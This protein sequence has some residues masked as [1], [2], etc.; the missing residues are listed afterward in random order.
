MY[1]LLSCDHN[2]DS[3]TSITFWNPQ[4]GSKLLS[5]RGPSAS[6]A[7]LSFIRN[8]G[9][10]IAE[11]GKPFIHFWQTGHSLQTS[12]RILCP[13]KVNAMAWSHTGAFLAVAIKE[14]I[15]IWQPSSGRIVCTLDAGHHRDV[16]VLKFAKDLSYLVSGGADGLVLAW[17]FTPAFTMSS[18][19]PMYSWANHSFGVTDLW[20]GIGG[21]KARIYS[22]SLD[23]TMKIYSLMTG[24]V[25]LSIT[26]PF[27]LTSVAADLVEYC[28]YVGSVQGSIYGVIPDDPGIKEHAHFSSNNVFT[29]HNKKYVFVILQLSVFQK[30]V[31]SFFLLQIDRVTALTVSPDGLS[32]ASGDESGAIYIWCPFSRAVKKVVKE[33]GNSENGVTNLLF[34]HDNP[35]EL[36]N[37]APKICFPAVPKL[38]ETME[39]DRNRSKDSISIWSGKDKNGGLTKNKGNIDCSNLDLLSEICSLRS[40]LCQSEK[41]NEKLH[42]F[43]VDSILDASRPK[44]CRKRIKK[45]L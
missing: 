19:S 12:R 31:H 27:A 11:M 24:D 13:G 6:P 14:K 9:F 33:P 38:I 36:K 22:V 44:P 37:R 4:N 18:K 41:I 29:K 43:Y 23:R 5:L 17:K 45:S 39:E 8:E 20:I 42:N 26:F 16:T 7:S 21:Y 3:N 30:I 28:V 40:K 32:F 15:N 2:K 1:V 10:S 35:E 34:W 25:L